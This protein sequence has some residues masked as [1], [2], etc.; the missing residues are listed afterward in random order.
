[1]AFD[2]DPEAALAYDRWFE[3]RWGRYAFRVEAAALLRA[4]GGVGGRKVLDVG[5]GT[6]RFTLE[7]QQRGADVIG[8]D[9]DLA[10]LSVARG[11][12]RAPL[13]QGDACA[14]PFAAG[15]FD[16][17]VAV[18]L[19]E[20]V[21][22]VGAVFDEL[23]RVTRPGGR[24]V[25]GSLNPRSPWGIANR[26]RF[27]EPPWTEAR[28]LGRQEL[29]TLGARFGRAR[30]SGHLYAPEGLPRLQALGAPL[31]VAGRLAPA[32]GAFQVLTV[33]R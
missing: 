29:I 10:M 3:R 30:I 22:D 4:S 7:L 14:L 9:R 18:T 13:I 11:R 24:F 5:C 21:S 32:L 31:E 6:G 12:L 8:L 23:A 33:E 20:F 27:R 17:A 26:R 1:M 15:A 2:A 19:C 16:L 25:V 28:F